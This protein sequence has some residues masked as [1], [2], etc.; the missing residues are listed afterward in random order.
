MNTGIQDAVS[1]AAVLHEIVAKH[2]EEKALDAWEQKR[3]KIAHSVV[4]VTD[5]MTKLATVS[6]DA[7]KFLRNVAI[8]IIGDLP[9]AQHA[10]AERLSELDNR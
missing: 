5:R 7:G 6:S 4:N 10:I 2:A 1:L 8:E 3:L 9:F